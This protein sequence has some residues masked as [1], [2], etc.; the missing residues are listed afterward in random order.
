MNLLPFLLLLFIIPS[1]YG[2]INN[3]S[4]VNFIPLIP[5]QIQER[6]YTEIPRYDPHTIDNNTQTTKIE[7]TDTKY[8][9]QFCLEKTIVKTIVVI[10]VLL[11]IV[12]LIL[13]LRKLFWI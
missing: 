9:V 4:N 2:Q 12:F 8:C 3:Q 10:L 13:I 1:T 7:T 6:N 5:S 11:F